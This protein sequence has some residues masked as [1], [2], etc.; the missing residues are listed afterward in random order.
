MTMKSL[1]YTLPE[2]ISFPNIFHFVIIRAEPAPKVAIIAMKIMKNTT[3]S[4]P[5]KVLL[6]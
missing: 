5:Y 3:I 4:C 6:M 2:L 1:N